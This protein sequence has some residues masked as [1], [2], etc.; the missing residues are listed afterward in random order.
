MSKHHR[1]ISNLTITNDYEGGKTDNFEKDE[2]EETSGCCSYCLPSDKREVTSD[3][4]KKVRYQ[5]RRFI[6]YHLV[7]ICVDM[8]VYNKIWQMI[9]AE[10]F[11]AWVAY[12]CYIKM[13]NCLIYIYLV[14]L[15]INGVLG[16]F[17]VFDLGKW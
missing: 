16:C 5:L 8:F 17:Y 3:E 12:C 6:C 15:M 7:F 11:V 9:C 14:L 4:G 10:L 2:A 13:S 1:S